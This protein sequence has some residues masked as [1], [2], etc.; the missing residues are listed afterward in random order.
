MLLPDQDDFTGKQFACVISREATAVDGGAAG[1]ADDYVQ[2]RDLVYV[3]GDA[4]M[5][6]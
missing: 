4:T 5:R 6:R 2:A 3:L 1:T